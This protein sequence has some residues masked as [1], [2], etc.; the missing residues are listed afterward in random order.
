MVCI[1]WQDMNSYQCSIATLGRDGTN[2]KLQ[3]DKLQHNNNPQQQQQQQQECDIVIT[4]LLSPGDTSK[5]V[6]KLYSM[7]L[8]LGDDTGHIFPVRC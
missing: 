8:R 7:R 3:A 4:E 1:D 6:G 5:N 2:V